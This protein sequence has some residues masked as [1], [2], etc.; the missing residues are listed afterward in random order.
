[1]IANRDQVVVEGHSLAEA[2]TI[3]QQRCTRFGRRA[4]FEYEVRSTHAF[5]CRA[6]HA[7][8][9]SMQRPGRVTAMAEPDPK[10]SQAKKIDMKKSSRKMPGQV[11][12]EISQETK[13][14]K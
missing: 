9:T 14:Q 7:E 6:Q 13:S 10:K 2:S 12:P 4:Y 5:T 11:P 1:V 3:A 8:R